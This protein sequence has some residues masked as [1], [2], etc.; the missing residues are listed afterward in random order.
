M[1][2][3]LGFLLTLLVA[4]AIGLGTTWIAVTQ[5]AAY[6]GITIGAWTA[7]PKVGTPEIDPYARAMIARSGELPIGSGDGVAFSARADDT[8][9]PLDGR[10]EI[11]VAGMTP[12][13]RYWTIT[14]YDLAGHL[15]ANSIQRYG[16][17][18][19]EIVRRA[20]GVFEVTASPRARPGNWLPTGA[21]ERYVLVLRLYDTPVGVATRTGRD[22]PMPSITRGQCQ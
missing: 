11:T 10:C 9:R 16:F 15:V 12:Q 14:L 6:G 13:A 2:L 4:A 19:Q 3:L 7:W 8:G 17:N 21:I 22:A 20:D 1:R 5:G 18:S